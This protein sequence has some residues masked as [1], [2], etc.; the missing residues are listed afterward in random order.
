MANWLRHHELM[1]KESGHP[2]EA[3]KETLS[4]ALSSSHF[5]Y[6]TEPSASEKRRK[7]NAHEL[8]TRLS[9]FLWSSLPDETLSGLADSGELLAPGALRREFN[10]LFADEKLIM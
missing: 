8:A 6:L 9:Y 2:V 4:A 1:R 3:L 10:R 5:L 7:L